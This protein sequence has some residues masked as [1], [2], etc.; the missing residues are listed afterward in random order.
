MRPTSLFRL[1]LILFLNVAFAAS[2]EAV[3]PAT[4]TPSVKAVLFHAPECGECEDL[5]VTYVPGLLELHVKRLDIAG[6][7]V[8]QTEGAALYQ[9]AI[10]EYGLPPEWVGEPVVLVGRR[11]ISGLL[12]IGATLGDE[13]DLLAADP[14][15]IRW[16]SLPGLETLLPQAVQ[17]IRSRAA[18]TEPLPQLPAE[19]FKVDRRLSNR[20]GYLLG[21][22]VLI[23]MIVAIG[24]S[25]HRVLHPVRRPDVRAWWI[26][27]T[28]VVGLG[29][30]TYTAYTSLADVAPLCGPVGDCLTVQ[31]SEY[32]RIAGIPMGVLGLVGY[33][34]ILVSW[35][36]ALNRSPH[37][38][39]WHWFPWGIA[40]ISVLFSLRLT[41]LSLFVIGATCVWCLGSAVAVSVL[42]WLLSGKT[43]SRV[44]K[45]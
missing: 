11:A 34:A 5:L 8:S 1:C 12:A 45:I 18:Q 31:Q 23:G 27:A 29:I 14:H 33:G 2:A 6:I 44:R 37:G 20:L 42:L 43:A 15:A 36:I 30:S 24:F 22:V 32:A 25:V 38:S 10:Q 13:L 28:L 40:M 16:P 7:D 19:D 39:G 26:V 17:N 4:G 3:T 35:L 41:A 21:L 9:A